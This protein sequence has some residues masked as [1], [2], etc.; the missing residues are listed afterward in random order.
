MRRKIKLICCKFALYMIS[1]CG[2]CNISCQSD[3][4]A[5]QF[6]QD[7]YQP[8]PPGAVR[9]TGYLECDIQNSIE[10]W[11]KGVV[12]YEKLVDFFRYG[13]KQFALGE[14]WGKAVRSGC[15]FY[16][17][18]QDSQL[19]DIL[20]KTVRDLLTTERE[21]GSVSC[22]PPSQQPDGPGGD[23]WERN[24]VL[25]GLQ[26]YYEYQIANYINNGFHIGS[27]HADEGDKNG[28]P[29]ELDSS[30]IG[31]LTKVTDYQVY[32]L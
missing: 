24:Y 10:H 23:L 31:V 19:K 12:P 4:V 16:R 21:N 18:T 28:K 17:Y 13:R 6:V 20:D 11:N 26:D 3:N 15:M 5:S 1:L 32:H 14:M 9:L 29:S 30:E 8:L 27:S 25:L 2:L 7:E 22:V